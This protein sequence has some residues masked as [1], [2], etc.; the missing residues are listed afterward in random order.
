MKRQSLGGDK[1]IVNQALAVNGADG[2]APHV[3][4]PGDVVEIIEGENAAREGLQKP[5]PFWFPMIF[6]AGFLDWKSDVFWSQRLTR[7]KRS[8]GA[9]PQLA[10]DIAKIFLND[11]LTE[12]FMREIVVVQKVV[13]KKVPER[14]M[15]DIVEQSGDTHVF[16]DERRRRALVGQ[17]FAQ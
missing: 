17:N 11:C 8:T 4:I 2:D 7:S 1:G 14:S 15:T 10:N 16:F 3:R 13:I 6:L 12:V 9:T 5:H